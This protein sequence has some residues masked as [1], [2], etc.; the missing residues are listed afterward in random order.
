MIVNYEIIGCVR[1]R[2]C[3]VGGMCADDGC[4]HLGRPELRQVVEVA[5]YD[6][7]RAQMQSWLMSASIRGTVHASARR[8]VVGGAWRRCRLTE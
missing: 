4:V 7:F 8:A 5:R 2:G 3:G 1:G 6:M